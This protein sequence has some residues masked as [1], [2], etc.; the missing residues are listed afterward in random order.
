M[1][2]VDLWNETE[3][4]QWFLH[5]QLKPKLIVKNELPLSGPNLLRLSMKYKTDLWLLK[6]H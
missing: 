3:T 2:N 1:P 6:S 5:L 4:W